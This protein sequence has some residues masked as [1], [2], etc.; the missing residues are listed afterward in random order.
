MK[1]SLHI[2]LFLVTLV[3]LLSIIPPFNNM[4]TLRMNSSVLEEYGSA[5][6]I[7]GSGVAGIDG[8]FDEY[9]LLPSS[10]KTPEERLRIVHDSFEELFLSF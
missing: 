2:L 5:Q 10:Q 4:L 6:I 9:A 7:S 3:F 1:K 8:L